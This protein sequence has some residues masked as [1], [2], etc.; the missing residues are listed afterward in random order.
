M[1]WGGGLPADRS[2]GRPS[3]VVAGARSL[4]NRRRHRCKRC[5]GR[6][7]HGRNATNR[8]EAAARRPT[9]GGDG[10]AR[11]EWRPGPD[12]V[13][14]TGPPRG[15]TVPTEPAPSLLARL[16]NW[17][18]VE[19]PDE[20][21]PH[22][23]VPDAPVQDASASQRRP[24][25]S[26]VAD[27]LGET[28]IVPVGDLFD[29]D[30]AWVA[31]AQRNIAPEPPDVA[32]AQPSHDAQQPDLDAPQARL[33][34]EQPRPDAPQPRLDPQQTTLDAPPWRLDP[35][36]TGLDA[37]EARGNTVVPRTTPRDR[38]GTPPIAPPAPTGVPR[39]RREAPA[40]R[41]ARSRWRAAAAL[42]VLCA[43]VVVAVRA[44][45][46]GSRSAVTASPAAS[47]VPA[48]PPSRLPSTASVATT[49]S[50][51]ECAS[52]QM[53][54]VAPPASTGHPVVA[55]LC[56][57]LGGG[58]AWQVGCAPGFQA[59]CDPSLQ[60]VIDCLRQAGAQ[61]HG[62]INER[63]VLACDVPVGSGSGSSSG[64]GSAGAPP[65]RPPPA[66]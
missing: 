4:P 40:R 20:P 58:T 21:A 59:A 10:V 22:E 50:V 66:A 31:A 28:L 60:A 42:V 44:G 61:Q 52:M 45:H 47:T 56:Y 1:T 12:R 16:W 37:E 39:Q 5:T 9:G 8:Y 49:P 35:Q 15:R 26:E 14:D 32:A 62:A 63:N 46:G 7:T 3:S 34:V 24:R 36:L 11:R 43:A 23:S 2:C 17:L 55:G 27:S 30:Q 33:G 48:Q 64:S 53:Q 38:R 19:V 51:S 25:S 6:D 41:C 13:A 65:R 57:T 54:P 18:T 29:V